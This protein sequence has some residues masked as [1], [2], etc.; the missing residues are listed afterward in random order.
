M[1][2]SEWLKRKQR[3][4]SQLRSLNPAWE[5]ILYHQVKDRSSLSHHAV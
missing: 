5:I 3:I 4:D 2:E 1:N